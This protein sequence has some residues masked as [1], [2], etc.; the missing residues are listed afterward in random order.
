M[1]NFWKNKR[2]LITGH[3]GFKGS[4]LTLLLNSKSAKLYG[5]SK[6]K[7]SNTKKKS[8]FNTCNLNSLIKSYYI[9][10]CDYKSLYKKVNKIKPDIIFHLA[11][12]SIISDSFEKPLETFYTNVLGTTNLLECIKNIKEVKT[13]IIVSTDRT[14]REIINFS[15]NKNNKQKKLLFNDPYRVSKYASELIIESYCD[16]YFKNKKSIVTACSGNIIGGGDWSKNRIITEI[17][18]AWVSNKSILIRNPYNIGNWQYVLDPLNGYI[19]LAER[20]HKKKIDYEIVN[21]GFKVERNTNV[22]KLINESLKYLNRKNFIK[23][24]LSKSPKI[25]NKIE[26]LQKGNRSKI[27]LNYKP[28]YSFSKSI[29]NTIKWY[30]KY[31]EG[32]SP[33]DLCNIEIEEYIKFR[34]R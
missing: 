8:L 25:G 19:R 16:S 33:L 6:N 3:T 31:Y 5:I 17:M 9:D 23:F 32:M 4:W 34:E 22:K 15:S 27:N 29:E 24:K 7:L 28:K 11:A 20:I 30:M 14:R 2:V 18:K 26:L 13:A 1:N 10:I 12:Q 21:F